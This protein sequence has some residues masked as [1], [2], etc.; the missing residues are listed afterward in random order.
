MRSGRVVNIASDAARVGS[1]GEA[2]YA[3]CKA[4]MLNFTRT[5]TDTISFAGYVPL[6]NL[7]LSPQ[8]GFASSAAGNPVSADV[9]WAKL[10]LT[11][12]TAKRVWGEG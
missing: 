3:A 9:Q 10:A 7:A 12:Q 1:S 6:E 11:A 4:G 8:C 5:G 2:V